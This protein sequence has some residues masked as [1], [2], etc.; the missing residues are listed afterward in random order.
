VAG[1]CGDFRG[2]CSDQSLKLCEVLHKHAASFFAIRVYCYTTRGM[3]A[4]YCNVAL[5]VPLRTTF[6]YAVPEALRGQVMPGSRVLA[7]FRKKSLVGVVVEMVETPPEGTKIREISKLLDLLPA[8]PPKLIELGHW[9]AGYYLAPIGE[10]FRAMLPPVTDLS[11]RREIVLTEAT[12]G[13][14]HAAGGRPA[15]AQREE[16]ARTSGLLHQARDRA[17]RFAA[18]AKTRLC[19]NSREYAG[20][21]A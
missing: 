18:A 9:I 13:P 3:P 5:P 12:D 14:L 1:Y 16:G 4:V 10:A 8:L 2:R 17:G 15:E 19:R 21:E 20:T 6:T 11:P 7:P